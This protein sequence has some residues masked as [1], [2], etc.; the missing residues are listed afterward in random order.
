[1]EDYNEKINYGDE[2]TPILRDRLSISSSIYGFNLFDKN[3][4]KHLLF[5][6]SKDICEEGKNLLTDG[7]PDL[8]EVFK[9]RVKDDE[10]VI[11]NKILVYEN[12]DYFS[13]PTLK[14]LYSVAL[15]ILRCKVNEGH[16]KERTYSPKPLDYTDEDIKNMP[17]S[18]RSIAENKLNAYK[19][20]LKEIKEYNHMINLVEKAIDDENGSLAWS[21]LKNGIEDNQIEIINTI[22]V[23]EMLKK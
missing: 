8:F 16:Y 10:V 2:K 6:K 11:S 1:M 12:N 4:K 19:S 13:I 9:E 5:C 14:D 23:S 21:I 15:Y 20:S 7:K 18:F 17:E 3:T 22:I